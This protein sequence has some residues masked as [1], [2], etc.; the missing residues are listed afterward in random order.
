MYRKVLEEGKPFNPFNM[1]YGLFIPNGLVECSKIND[2]VKILMGRLFQYA[3][4]NGKAYPFRKSLAKECGWSIKKLDRII[5]AAK[6]I[7]LI[8]TKPYKTNKEDANEYNAPSEYIF[9]YSKVY[10]EGNDADIPLVK[11]DKGGALKNDKGGALKNEKQNKII[12]K[13]NHSKDKDKSL[14]YESDDSIKFDP[15]KIKRDIVPIKIKSKTPDQEEDKPKP[16]PKYVHTVSDLRNYNECKQA[17]AI[18]HRKDSKAE[19]E[20]LDNLHSL[21]SGKCK[22]PYHKI[23]IPEQYIDLEWDMDE[24]LD[25]FKYQLK[26]S[27]K[28]IKSIG[29]FIFFQGY[30]KVGPKKWI[31]DDERSWSPLLYWHQKNEQD[32]CE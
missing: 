31:M 18:C 14:S 22:D 3:G 1:F 13:E 6:D 19:H 26:H 17:G 30:K 21:F 28:P 5:K 9:L 16:K 12:Y 32:C 7:K 20:S 15:K 8:K 24:L 25:V 29:Q 10:D 4:E 11:N 27:K 2:S 23:L